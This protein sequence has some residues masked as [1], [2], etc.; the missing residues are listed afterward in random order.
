MKKKCIHN[1]CRRTQ[2]TQVNTHVA[3][4]F[5]LWKFINSKGDWIVLNLINKKCRLV[6]QS[7]V[8]Q[9]HEK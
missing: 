4:V 1:E 3:V 7:N 2:S 8:I 6:L 5:I 9:I